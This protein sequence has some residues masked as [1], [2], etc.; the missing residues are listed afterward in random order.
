MDMHT[1]FRYILVLSLFTLVVNS[2]NTCCAQGKT[3]V[4][5]SAV[6][7]VVPV[8]DDAVR[9]GAKIFK[10]DCT[11]CKGNKYTVRYTTCTTCKGSGKNDKGEDCSCCN[12]KKIIAVRVKCFHCNGTGK[13]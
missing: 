3:K 6:K 10:S 8:L 5:S 7:K 9:A 2:S 11:V 12:G 4:F 1:K 13:K